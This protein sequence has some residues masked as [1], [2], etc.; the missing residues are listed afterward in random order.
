MLL[1]INSFRLGITDADAAKID[2]S[3]LDSI[4]QN[5]KIK[6][7]LDDGTYFDMPVIRR[8]ETSRLKGIFTDSGKL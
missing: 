4:S 6:K 7:A 3:S 8:E 5:A 2:T 1:T